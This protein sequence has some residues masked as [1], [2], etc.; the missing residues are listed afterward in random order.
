MEAQAWDGAAGD[1][2]E[3]LHGPQNLVFVNECVYDHGLPVTR[4]ALHEFESGGGK[5]EQVGGSMGAERGVQKPRRGGSDP[6]VATVR[7]AEAHD[8]GSGRVAHAQIE[9]R[10]LHHYRIDYTVMREE[11]GS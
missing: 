1:E 2:F 3:G 7:V 11:E 8:E 9:G 10:G 6:I 5:L 4:E